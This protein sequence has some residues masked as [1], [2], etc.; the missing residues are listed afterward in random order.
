[1]NGKLAAAR[2]WLSG[3]FPEEALPDE[4]SRIQLFVQE[5]AK[6]VFREGGTIVHGSHPDIREPLLTAAEHFKSRSTNGAANAPLG[7]Y[8][9]RFFLSLRRKTASISFVGVISAATE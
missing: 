3:S 9:S 4:K 2:I 5:F 7:L 8:V 6:A 1:M